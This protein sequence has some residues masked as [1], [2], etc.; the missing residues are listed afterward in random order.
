M[1][2][3]DFVESNSHCF[4]CNKSIKT[5]I[6]I[7]HNGTIY[8]RTCAK[9]LNID[10]HNIPNFTKGIFNNNENEEN[11]SGSKSKNIEQIIDKKRCKEYLILRCSKLCEI[12]SM[13]TEKLDDIYTRLEINEI[14][15]EDFIYLRNLIRKMNREKTVFSEK[16]IHFCY[17]LTF[18]L[19]RLIQENPD[20]QFYKDLLI[21]LNRK[22]HLTERQFES[23]ETD[24][25]LKPTYVTV[26]NLK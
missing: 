6:A 23:I 10:L 18:E 14:T 2:C 22:A 26:C 20:N 15:D 12:Q 24:L 13:N 7:L 1:T 3:I 25:K 8:G 16:N 5:N 4:K 21:Y 11:S 9:K 17:I 19:N